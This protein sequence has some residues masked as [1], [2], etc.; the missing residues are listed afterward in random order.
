M[1]E[2][3]Q[4]L[5]ERLEGREGDCDRAGEAGLFEF[6]LPLQKIE[7]SFDKSLFLQLSAD[8]PLFDF[9]G[10]EVVLLDEGFSLCF[11]SLVLFFLNRC[12]LFF[13]DR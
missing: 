3:G 5:V 1:M 13:L 6:S 9:L 11:F 8:F 7:L 12:I 2:P 10:C 4:I